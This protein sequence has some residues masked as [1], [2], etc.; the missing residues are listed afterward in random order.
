MKEKNRKSLKDT[1]LA[2][3]FL[4]LGVL[5]GVLLVEWTEGEAAIPEAG[6][7]EASSSLKSE[8]PPLVGV[9]T[10]ASGY[11]SE[12]APDDEEESKPKPTL[13]PSDKIEVVSNAD[14]PMEKIGGLGDAENRLPDQEQAPQEAIESCDEFFLKKMGDSSPL[15]A[16]EGPKK[17]G[18]SVEFDG[19]VNPWSLMTLTRLPDDLVTLNV[20]EGSDGRSFTFESDHGEITSAGATAASWQ[21]PSDPGIYCVRILQEDSENIMCLHVAVM[22]PWDGESETLN[23]YKIGTY[24]DKPYRDNP[25]YKKPRGFIEVTEENQDT[26]VSP[27]LQLS[28]FV[29]KQKADFPKYMLLDS[30]LLLKLEKLIE[31]LEEGGREASHL[32]ISS[33]YRTPAYNVALGNT[34]SYSRHLYGD[35]ADLFVDSNRDGKLDDL[36]F[37]GSTDDGDA[38]MIQKAVESVSGENRLFKGGLGFYSS[39]NYR[40]PFIH[41][42]TRGYEA[43]WKK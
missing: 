6:A 40:N 9:D 15:I 3:A 29:C 42:D 7:L 2:V 21:A 8:A 43:R 17:S 24:Q 13:A 36:D 34:T 19:L 18:F 26:W 39:A 14:V 38:V 27:H 35:A 41:I 22:K 20:I 30:R 37:S 1:A 32:Y 12:D 25:R 11:N 5:L 33:G 10:T 28:Q 4:P 31:E 23:G 16:K